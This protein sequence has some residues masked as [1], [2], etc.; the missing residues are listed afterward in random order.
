M[1]LSTVATN[2]V[3]VCEQQPAHGSTTVRDASLSDIPLY[4]DGNF[5]EVYAAR[6]TP[7]LWIVEH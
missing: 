6:I 5:E 4:D 7:P 1:P 2:D 3:K